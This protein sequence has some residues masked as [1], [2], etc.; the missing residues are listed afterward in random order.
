MKGTLSWSQLW[1]PWVC[2]LACLAG[3]LR[4][5]EAS[6]RDLPNLLRGFYK[7]AA[8]AHE[9]LQATSHRALPV[10]VHSN[11]HLLAEALIKG[12][13]IL[14]PVSGQLYSPGRA[15]VQS[16]ARV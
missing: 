14:C 6:E 7:D 15:C 13:F 12:H 9:T 1:L 5:T 16:P 2:L 3:T 11:V 10:R 8:H 4:L